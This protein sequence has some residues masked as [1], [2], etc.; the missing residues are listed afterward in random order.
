[1]EYTCIYTY[2]NLGLT[3]LLAWKP[4]IAPKPQIREVPYSFLNSVSSDPS[5]RRESTCGARSGGGHKALKP[6]RRETKDEPQTRAGERRGNLET[7]G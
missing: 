4:W 5:S 1:M 2:I 3:R 7:A 6:R